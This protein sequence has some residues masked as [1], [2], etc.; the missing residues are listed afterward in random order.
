M[1]RVEFKPLS[2]SVSRLMPQ[3]SLQVT[4]LQT[5]NCTVQTR[6]CVDRISMLQVECSP[7]GLKEAAYL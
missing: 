3:N 5:L 1:S 7:R 4:Q 2:S 6:T